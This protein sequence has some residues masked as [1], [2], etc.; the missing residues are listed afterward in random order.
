MGTSCSCDL[1]KNEP[2]GQAHVSANLTEHFQKHYPQGHVFE[3]E[4]YTKVYDAE[5]HLWFYEHRDSGIK[6]WCEALDLRDGDVGPEAAVVFH[7]TNRD[8][9]RKITDKRNVPTDVFSHL[10]NQDC[11][12]H[13]FGNG[14]ITAAQEP[15]LFGQKD[16][17]LVNFFWPR[18]TDAFKLPGGKVKSLEKSGNPAAGPNDPANLWVCAEILEDERYEGAVDFCI[19][20]LVSHTSV[21]T[22][23]LRVTPDLVGDVELGCNRW[24]EKQWDG[25]DIC[26][27]HFNEGELGRLSTAGWTGNIDILKQRAECLEK[28]LGPEHHET[29]S[30]LSE[31]A[32]LLQ[33]SG[34]YEEAKPLVR[35]VLSHE[36]AI[37]QTAKRDPQQFSKCLDK[38]MSDLDGKAEAELRLRRIYEGC[39]QILGPKHSFTFTA[40]VT[41][42]TM[43]QARGKGDE[44]EALLGSVFDI[45]EEEEVSSCFHSLTVLQAMNC[46]A[47]MRAEKGKRH[48]AEGLLQRALALA[49]EV[50]EPSHPHIWQTFMDLSSLQRTLGAEDKARQ[51]LVRAVNHCETQLGPSHGCTVSALIAL[52]V[53]ENSAGRF[54]E[55]ERLLRQTV[56]I[57]QIKFGDVHPDTV[58][59]VKHLAAFLKAR[60]RQEEAAYL[61]E[62]ALEGQE[63]KDVDLQSMDVRWRVASSVTSSDIFAGK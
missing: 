13:E 53:H 15:H 28:K 59:V 62:T 38:V 42:T 55:A 44:A 45:E 9:M 63:E 17:A 52:A 2:A 24:G 25:R 43:L 22:L 26:V 31:L 34:R 11:T 19:P 56:D 7:Y 14:L 57:Q 29:V 60:N 30:V 10:V 18:T 49:I 54:S 36:Q 46:L 32:A 50:L 58:V 33:A 41:L 48:R 5:L 21:Y 27:V 8:A 40:L 37:P 23:G 1:Q 51:T 12:D 6:V 3:A 39:L 16:D 20:L 61:L 4:Q 47:T 35:R